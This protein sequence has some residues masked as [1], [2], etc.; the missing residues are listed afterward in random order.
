MSSLPPMP[1]P[2]H[3]TRRSEAA[4]GWTLVL[5]IIVGCV[6][7]MHSTVV[8][9][10]GGGFWLGLIYLEA[11]VA[12]VCLLGLMYGDAGVIVRS[13][14]TVF[15]LLTQNERFA[16]TVQLHAACVNRNHR[17]NVTQRFLIMRKARTRDRFAP[18][19]TT[20]ASCESPA[21]GAHEDLR[22][23]RGLNEAL[24]QCPA[25]ERAKG[26][27]RAGANGAGQGGYNAA[28]QS[29]LPRVRGAECAQGV[30][31]A[32]WYGLRGHARAI[33]ATSL[34]HIKA[35]LYL[36]DDR[37]EDGHHTGV[38]ERGIMPPPIPLRALIERPQ[39][40]CNSGRA[41]SQTM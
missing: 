12:L 32:L 25:K 9:A 6:G 14:A 5:V 3:G 8:G 13:P 28:A 7:I 23:A 31:R 35:H 30:V 40:T 24:A 2:D 15:P 38:S 19:P 36:V 16:F 20:P 4:C 27:Q 11:A 18:H 39:T 21:R 10:A 34:L 29:G 17:S 1:T 33:L 41:R 26:Q 22:V 37:H